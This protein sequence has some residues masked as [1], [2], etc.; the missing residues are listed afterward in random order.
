MG[1]LG[2][3]VG[4]ALGAA[5]GGGD[6]KIGPPMPLKLSTVGRKGEAGDDWSWGDGGLG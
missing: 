5:M 4:M 2:E 6:P 3:K 1:N